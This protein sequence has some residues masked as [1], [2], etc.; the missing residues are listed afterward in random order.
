VI[1]RL[2]GH[3]DYLHALAFSDDGKRLATCG[4]RGVSI[5]DPAR[6]IRML[7]IDLNTGATQCLAWTGPLLVAGGGVWD[8]PGEI[9][10][11]T[12]E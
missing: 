3:P 12:T 10:V 5:W 8:V 6:G 1:R 7:R 9:H 4:G 11:W 2:E